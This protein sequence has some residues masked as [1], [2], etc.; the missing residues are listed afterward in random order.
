MVSLGGLH[1][2]MKFITH[3]ITPIRTV[4]LEQSC[5]CTL[6]LCTGRKYSHLEL[7][8]CIFFSQ[9]DLFGSYSG[10]HVAPYLLEVGERSRSLGRTR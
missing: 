5:A 2:N 3:T 10:Q 9:I 7:P 6:L 4:N 1:N 8:D